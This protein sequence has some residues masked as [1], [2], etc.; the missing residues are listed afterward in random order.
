MINELKSQLSSF[1]IS[2]FGGGGGG[3]FSSSSGTLPKEDPLSKLKSSIEQLFYRIA[4]IEAK[5]SDLYMRPRMDYTDYAAGGM[6]LYYDIDVPSRIADQRPRWWYPGVPPTITSSYTYKVYNYEDT[7]SLV[8]LKRPINYWALWLQPYILKTYGGNTV[9]TGILSY[10]VPDPP[11]PGR[12]DTDYTTISGTRTHTDTWHFRFDTENL[13]ASWVLTGTNS[14]TTWNSFTYNGE[15]TITQP[16][17]YTLTT[18]TETTTTVTDLE[19]TTRY[20]STW[21]TT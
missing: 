1:A 16:G 4:D 5:L 18:T 7:T 9:S 13:D 2:S 6:R 20:T 3:V 19:T 17:L 15:I 21:T 14:N 11:A 10:Y 12:T 8:T